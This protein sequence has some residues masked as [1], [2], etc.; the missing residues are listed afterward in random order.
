MRYRVKS[1]GEFQCPT[2]GAPAHAGDTAWQDG[3][4]VFCS[5]YCAGA[6]PA[7]QSPRPTPKPKESNMDFANFITIAANDATRLRK[8]DVFRLVDTCPNRHQQEFVAWL[9]AQRPDLAEEARECLAEL[10][11]QKC[12][13]CRTGEG[14]ACDCI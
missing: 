1:D 12:P 6:N 13:Y 8:V 14:H 11:A 3:Q 5:A 2:C 9:S 4:Q 10:G 7:K